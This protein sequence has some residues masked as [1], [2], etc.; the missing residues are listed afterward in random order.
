MEK[1]DINLPFIILVR[2]AGVNR[3]PGA[4]GAAPRQAAA[5]TRPAE[6]PLS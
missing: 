4:R 5:A 1:P 2:A 3:R 6:R